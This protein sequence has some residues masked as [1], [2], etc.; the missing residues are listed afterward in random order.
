MR[1]TIDAKTG[2][3][4]EDHTGGVYGSFSWTRLA[5]ILRAAGE[6]QNSETP[7]IYEIWND[8]IRYKVERSR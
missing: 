3:V 8:G 4:V 6:L 1:I 7:V 2:E 5:E